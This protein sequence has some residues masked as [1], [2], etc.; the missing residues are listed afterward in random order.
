MAQVTTR[1]LSVACVVGLGLALVTAGSAPAHTLP[2]GPGAISKIVVKPDGLP[3]R[4]FPDGSL[5]LSWKAPKVL[6][7]K[8]SKV[9]SYKV[10]CGKAIAIT[11]LSRVHL[12]NVTDARRRVTCSITPYAGKIAGRSVN[13]PPIVT[14][15]AYGASVLTYSSSLSDLLAGRIHAGSPAISAIHGFAVPMITNLD[16]FPAVLRHEGTLRVGLLRVTDLR[17]L[18]DPSGTTDEPVEVFVGFDSLTH[19]R[20]TLLTARAYDIGHQTFVAHAPTDSRSLS[21]LRT[22]GLPL[23]A[24]QTVGVY[25]MVALS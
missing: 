12:E 6:P 18:D 13:A 7:G 14:Y 16:K 3:G 9:T 2:L 21:W 19:Q 15:H 10:K 23:T 25:R 8:T 24:D 22:A 1:T 17:L 11:K 20:I 4:P 5:R